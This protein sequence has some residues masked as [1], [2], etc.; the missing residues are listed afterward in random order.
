MNSPTTTATTATPSTSSNI[1]AAEAA[2]DAALNL[3]STKR[4]LDDAFE[5]L[6]NAVAPSE[7][8]HPPSK[9]PHTIRSLYSTLA[10]YGIK[11]KESRP[12]PTPLAETPLTSRSTPH[13]TAILSRAA[14]RTRKA[15]PFKFSG[16][17]ATAP[18]LPATAEYRPS[19]ITAFLL[20]LSTFKLA[21]YANK[22]PA[23]DAVAAAKCG[24]IN[25]GKDRLVCGLCKSSWVVGGRDGMNRD[26]ANAL[27]E[28]QRISLVDMHKDGCPWKTRQCDPTIYRVPL[29]SPSLMVKDIKANA[30]ALDPF[31]TNIEIKHPLQTSTQL[32]SLKSTV[33]SQAPQ[34]DSASSASDHVDPDADV[35]MAA[36][37]DPSEPSTTAILTSLFGW[38]LAPVVPQ[39]PSRRT[40]LSRANSLAPS[41][42]PR[43]PSLS[44]ASSVR[45][46]TPAPSVHQGTPV[47]PSAVSSAEFTFRA[48]S[49]ISSK[50]DTTL[51]HCALCQRRV[52][53]WA[54][55]PQA[56]MEPPSTPRRDSVETDATKDSAADSTSTISN[57]SVPATPL[58]KAP[59][60]RQFD[61][62]K[63]HRSYCPYVVRS[64]VVPTLPVP[65]GSNATVPVNAQ[66]RSSAASQVNGQHGN[67][68]VEGWRAVLTVVLRYGMGQRQR[69]GLDFVQRLRGETE[70]D[71]PM[72]VDGVKA[73][74]AGVKSR[75]GK[76]LLHY[77]KGLLG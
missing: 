71:E 26:A 34:T 16:P 6:D 1:P 8:E 50:R 3:R 22:P 77:V 20:R 10:K 69:L 65:P 70:G 54:F 49:N 5:S 29:Q 15:L 31:Q 14:T 64:T 2:S 43:T 55:A 11:T 32:S 35:F 46:I 44:R 13:L 56:A 18:A 66:T 30:V 74:V 37:R 75:G 9:R 33:S 68:A 39:E 61:L 73:M 12:T 67:Q 59:S 57:A 24:W 60:Q 72:E 63:E 23:I 52:G 41:S 48:P 36:P 7:V 47:T 28:K 62:L 58:R 42:T 51:L 25:D 19:S 45:Q 17:S 40:S 76:D 4:K 53:L 38:S 27:V 21:T